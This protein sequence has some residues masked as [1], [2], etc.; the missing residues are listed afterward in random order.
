MAESA[1]V[2]AIVHAIY[3]FKSRLVLVPSKSSI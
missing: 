1:G 2:L 3:D